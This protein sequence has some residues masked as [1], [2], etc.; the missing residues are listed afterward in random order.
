MDA[1]ITIDIENLH[2]DDCDIAISD[3]RGVRSI[4]RD[5]NLVDKKISQIEIV[6]KKREN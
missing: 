5:V 4:Y 3:S 6:L 1:R 2:I